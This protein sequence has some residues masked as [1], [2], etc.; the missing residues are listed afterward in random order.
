VK[1]YEKSTDTFTSRI[2]GLDSD[3]PH[4]MVQHEGRKTL[5]IADGN[6]LRQY[7][8]SYVR[9]TDNELT[10]P[11]EY[12]ITRILYWNNNAYALTRNIKGG[13]AKVFAWNGAGVGHNGAFGVGADWA[14]SGCE[15]GASFAVITSRGQLLQFNGGGFDFDSP[16]ANLPVYF[17]D[18]PWTSNAATDSL[19]GKVASRGMEASGSTIYLNI[20]GEL[21]VPAG[22][23][24]GSYLPDMPSGLWCFD[25][26]VGLTHLAGVNYEQAKTLQPL[27]LS[28]NRL[29][30]ASA[31][32]A[33]TGDAVLCG[34]AAGISG[35]FAGQTYFAIPEGDDALQLALTPSDAKAGRAIILSGTP[36]LNDKYVFDSYASMGSGQVT[37]AGPLFV[38]KT[39]TMNPFYGAQVLFGARAIDGTLSSCGSLMSVG[40]G[41]NVGYFKTPRLSSTGIRDTFQ[42]A[43][44]VFK[45]LSLDSEAITVKWKKTERPG[46]PSRPAYEDSAVEFTGPSTFTV[47][48][49][50]KPF[51]DAVVGDEV[52]FITGAAAGYLA[53][54][55]DINKDSATYII[56]LDEVLPVE[57]GDLTDCVVDN[58]TK[59]ATITNES[60]DNPQNFSAR[61]IGEDG[62]W[63]QFKVEL[64]GRDV[65][66][67]ALKITSEPHMLP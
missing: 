15:Y 24:S 31:H 58:W 23:P 51:D 8:S 27:E 32:E 5:M 12:L 35:V 13:Q 38:I 54:I 49:T 20:N 37:N 33:Q 1:S 9:D 19:I 45:Q 3:H 40:L 60:E 10:I 55:T 59:L 7:D 29:V 56:T 4:P 2:T 16:L 30:F 46:L 14:Y 17:T 62:T 18:F 61:P 36:G 64:R 50:L 21:N 48:T 52:E 44:A 28:S 26:K 66:L 34:A 47:D 43:I 63:I 67:D 42:S 41:R 39:L 22:S 11:V 65:S 25:P 53:H 6:V 57:A